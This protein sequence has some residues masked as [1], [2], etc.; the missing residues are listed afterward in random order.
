MKTTLRKLTNAVLLVALGFA[1]YYA[2][3][4]AHE[5]LTAGKADD[6][7][8]TAPALADGPAGA[9]GNAYLKQALTALE[10]QTSIAAKASQTGFIEGR[11]IESTGGYLQQGQGQGRRFSL[12]LVGRVTDEPVRLWQVSN[13]KWLWTDLAWGEANDVQLRHVWRV[14]LRR[15]RKEL[16]DPQTEQV[17]PGEAAVDSLDPNL[18]AGLGGLPMLLKS[19][20]ANFRF[21]LPRK[22]VLWKNVPVYAMVG[23]WKEDR[24][25]ELLGDAASGTPTPGTPPARMP[26]HVLIALGASD[27]FPRRIEYRGGT[28][29]LSAAGVSPD[30]RYLYT[31]DQ[32][33]LRLD[34]KEPNFQADFDPEV[35]EYA[36]PHGVDWMDRTS[37]RLAMLRHRRE[38]AVAQ[39]SNPTSGARSR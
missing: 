16:A 28:D 18:W 8:P 23:Y 29:R 5:M 15:L 36:A 26:H 7:L 20:D 14:D 9:E 1:V 10:R 2:G 17:K 11:T 22:M 24:L 39:A 33:L 12:R 31:S 30:Q 19:L 25:A 34:L 38:V 37:E 27:L 4:V 6:P 13:G 35:F 32:P 3:P 21:E